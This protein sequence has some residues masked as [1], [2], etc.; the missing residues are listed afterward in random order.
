ML[1]LKEILNEERSA[2]I[3]PYYENNGKIE[4]LLL[5]NKNIWGFPKGHVEKGESEIKAAKRETSEETGLSNIEVHTNWKAT[6]NYIV[7]WDFE[8]NRKFE[9]PK[10][11]E[12]TYFLGK[13]NSKKVRLSHEHDAYKWLTYENALNTI[14][15]NKKLIKKANEHILRK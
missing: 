6:T 11:K 13:A 9:T 5:K 7:K 4:Y 14:S 2:G 1:K 15:F 10:Q 3:I 8:N 12:V